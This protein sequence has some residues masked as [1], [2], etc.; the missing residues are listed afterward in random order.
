MAWGIGCLPVRHNG[1]AGVVHVTHSNSP[2]ELGLFLAD[3]SELVTVGR[4]RHRDD[5]PV[6]SVQ[7]SVSRIQSP[8]RSCEKILSLCGQVGL[9]GLV[10]LGCL[11]PRWG[12]ML[13]LHVGVLC[14]VA[15]CSRTHAARPGPVGPVMH[16]PW[17]DKTDPTMGPGAGP[18]FVALV[19]LIRL[20]GCCWQ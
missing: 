17:P 9:V 16:L 1:P 7:R 8:A 3:G 10:C 14:R 19:P 15:R 13:L 20:A 2:A 11:A 18:L 6:S 12:E 5:S 4:E